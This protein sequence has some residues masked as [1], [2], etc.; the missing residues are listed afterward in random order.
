MFLQS[1][2]LSEHILQQKPTISTV[3]LKVLYYRKNALGL[4][5]KKRQTGHSI[6]AIVFIFQLWEI[7]A[8]IVPLFL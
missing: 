2:H 4:R 7:P 6:D 8:S 3:S 5:Q 1:L